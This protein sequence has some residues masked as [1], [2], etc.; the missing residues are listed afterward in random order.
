MGVRPNAGIYH[1]PFR[2]GM[3]TMFDVSVRLRDGVRSR[4]KFI[5]KEGMVLD[6]KPEE[7]RFESGKLEKRNEETSG[8]DEGE[9]VDELALPPP[10]GPS[11]SSS[12]ANGD[13]Y[14]S[15]DSGRVEGQ[16]LQWLRTV[17]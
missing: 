7:A 6:A 15:T 16:L 9:K 8:R 5:R 14:E 12:S 13:K 17:L 2:C 1:I 10:W 3:Q 4:L 11:S